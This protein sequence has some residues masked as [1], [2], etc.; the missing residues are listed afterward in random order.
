MSGN[1]AER[2]AAPRPAAVPKLIKT[3]PFRNHLNWDRHCVFPRGSNC[4]F[5]KRNGCAVTRAACFLPRRHSWDFGTRQAT[6]VFGRA[7]RRRLPAGYGR[8]MI[9]QRMNLQWHD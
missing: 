1:T 3:A 4:R 9:Y 7:G 8:S 5:A 2:D 6:F